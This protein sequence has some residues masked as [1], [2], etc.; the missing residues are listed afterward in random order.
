MLFEQ[1]TA[2]DVDKGK[3]V[4]DTGRGFG[5]KKHQVDERP[6]VKQKLGVTKLNVGEAFSQDGTA[7]AGM[8]LRD[9]TGAVI[10]TTCRQLRS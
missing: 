3:Q 8:I 1:N 4:V 2:V 9:N 5:N 7:G 10:F 6:Q